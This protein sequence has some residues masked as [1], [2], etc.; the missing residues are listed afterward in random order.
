MAVHIRLIQIEM[1]LPDVQS[2]ADIHRALGALK[3]YCK[4]QVNI[5]LAIEPFSDTDR[6]GFSITVIGTDKHAVEQ[7]SDRLITWIETEITGQSLETE[8]SWL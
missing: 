2:E 1:Y 8:V 5:A 3:R 6:G 4:N 7:E